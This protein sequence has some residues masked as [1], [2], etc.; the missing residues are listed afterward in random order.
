MSDDPDAEGIGLGLSWRGGIFRVDSLL[1]GMPA[2][3]CK[4]LQLDDALIAV[5]GISLRDGTM[6]MAEVT[7][8]LQQPSVFLRLVRGLPEP[9]AGAEVDAGEEISGSAKAATKVQVMREFELADDV[10]QSAAGTGA[11]VAGSV[12]SPDNASVAGSGAVAGR[13]GSHFYDVNPLP[14]AGDVK[15]QVLA[16]HTAQGRL[17]G[18]RVR[19]GEEAEREDAAEAAAAKAKADEEAKRRAMSPPRFD[20]DRAK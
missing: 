11:G 13:R 1:P 4:K 8:M 12:A 20:A 15:R 10:V 18:M 2:A 5:N 3:L 14:V 19:T 16:T 6:P 7:R 9:R 17:I